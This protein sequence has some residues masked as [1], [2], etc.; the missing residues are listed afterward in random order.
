MKIPF[1][2]I[3]TVE[4]LRHRA[5][6]LRRIRSFFDSR[7]FIEVETPILSHDVCVDRYIQPIGIPAGEV[8]GAST[9]V[10]HRDN[11]LWLQ[12][13][14]EF[15]MK[16]L[17]AA[18]ATKIYQLTKAFRSGE[19]GRLHNPEFT[20]LEWYRVGDDMVSGMDLLGEFICELLGLPS[21]EKKSYREVFENEIQINPLNSSID[22]L[23]AA[24]RHQGLAIDGL[25]PGAGG[26][27]FWLNLL[28]SQVIEPKLGRPI[29]LIIYD[30]PAS[31]SALAIVRKDEYP[32]AERFELYVDGLELANGYHELLDADELRTRNMRNNQ[33][34]IKDGRQLLP[35][36]SR[37][38]SA[39]SHGIPACAGVAL[40]VDRLV[41][42]ATG[43]QSIDDVLSFPI[44]IA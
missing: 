23:K 26:K 6:I 21:V 18:G 42:L 5:E 37:L 2:P 16:R 14:P 36:D 20:M 28:L 30:W 38:V 39:M 15:A 13:S 27:D 1:L 25:E 4:T 12:T 34:R 24:C 22:E 7:D 32:V 10:S 9:A 43:V 19:R 40:G 35:E 11:Q 44:E 3:A 8:L 33:L 17:L 29:P 41:M 31:Q